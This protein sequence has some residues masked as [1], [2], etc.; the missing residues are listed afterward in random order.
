MNDLAAMFDA[1]VK[2]AHAVTPKRV[3]H[4]RLRGYSYVGSSRDH[5]SAS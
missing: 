2:R 1:H 5:S 3:H 4:F